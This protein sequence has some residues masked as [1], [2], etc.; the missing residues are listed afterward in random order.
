MEIVAYRLLWHYLISLNGKEH[1]FSKT[2]SWRPKWENKWPHV[3]VIR[4]IANSSSVSRTSTYCTCLIIPSISWATVG[5]HGSKISSET[6][7]R[8]ACVRPSEG[9]SL[10]TW[11]IRSENLDIPAKVLCSFNRY[12]LD[13]WSVVLC[14]RCE[15]FILDWTMLRQSRCA[16][17]KYCLEQISTAN[18]IDPADNFFRQLLFVL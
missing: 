12:L 9:G 18:C 1:S 7:V 10:K 16:L 5:I 8:L 11:F 3:P 17:R 2:K 13:L 6:N 14:K 4:F 15:N